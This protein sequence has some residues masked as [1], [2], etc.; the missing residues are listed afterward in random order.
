[1]GCC[2]YAFR[3]VVPGTGGGTL[4][5]VFPDASAGVCS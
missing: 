1:M 4:G 3:E 2:A 5:S